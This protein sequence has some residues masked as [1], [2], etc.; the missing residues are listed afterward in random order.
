MSFS[1]TSWAWK[2]TCPSS[3]AKLVLLCLADHS[4]ADGSNARPPA[5]KTICKETQLAEHTVRNALSK[6]QEVRF[7]ERI[8]RFAATGRCQTTEY[9]LII[10]ETTLADLPGVADLPETRPPQ[11][12]QGVAGKTAGGSLAELPGNPIL[13]PTK[14]PKDTSLRSVARARTGVRTAIPLDWQPGLKGVAYAEQH[15]V[16]ADL[17]V[18]VEKFRNHH[19]ARANRMADW[20]AAWRTW[21]ANAPGFRRPHAANDRDPM[22]RDPS[23]LSGA[24]LAK[25][26]FMME[27]KAMEEQAARETAAGVL[28]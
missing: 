11:N 16:T 6:L 10:R 15:G 20:D 23:R 4:N 9:R 22:Q 24:P 28:V 1:L 21:C 13:E 8:E 12:C 26:R 7:I 27:R 17:A 14:V 19:I 3:A 25:Y 18:E 2:Q 5:I